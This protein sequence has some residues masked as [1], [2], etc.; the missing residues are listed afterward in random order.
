VKSDRFNCAS[1][2]DVEIVAKAFVSEMEMPGIILLQGQMGAGK[3]TFVKAFCKALG[4]ADE[5]SSPTFSLVNQYRS[6]NGT[7]IYHFDC[8]RMKS[9]EEAYD[10]GM[11]EYLS[12][13]AWCLI[14]WP[15]VIRE[16]LPA[17]YIEISI[18]FQGLERTIQWNLPAAKKK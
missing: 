11:E 3:T 8:Y 15:D 12:A 7:V 1:E 10:I 5:V 9:D 14:E 6:G 2:A 18:D 13:R 4:S 16:L 17:E